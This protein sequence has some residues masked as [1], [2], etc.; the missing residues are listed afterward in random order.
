MDKELKNDV[1]FMFLSIT[2]GLY[3]FGVATLIQENVRHPSV[4]Q[5]LADVKNL[6]MTG[7]TDV[8]GAYSIEYYRAWPA[9]HFI[10]TTIIQITGT[11]IETLMKYMPLF[12]LF[13]F[14]ILVYGA[15]KR[16]E[17]TSN[18]C[19]L[20]TLLALSSYFPMQSDSSP[21]GV[22]ILAYIPCFV[23]LTTS[24]SQESI[25]IRASS[26]LFFT[27]LILLHGFTSL[28]VILGL[29]SLSV[30]R[31]L[32]HEKPPLIIS[33]SVLFLTWYVYQAYRALV[34]G[35]RNWLTAPWDYI[36][37][38]G[39]HLE[40]LY[41]PTYKFPSAII[42]HYSQIFYII[43]YGIL[44]IIA[45][46]YILRN[47]KILK[48]RMQQVIPPL[49]W[50][51]GVFFILFT[52]PSRETYIR[53]FMLLLVPMIFTIIGTFTSHKLLI[54]LLLLCSAFI[55]PARYGL[56]GCFGQVLTTELVGAQFFGYHRGAVEPYYFYDGGE[57]HKVL[58][59][60]NPDA[61]TW[62][63]RWSVSLTEDIPFVLNHASYVLGGK[64]GGQTV[65]NNW[66]EAGGGKEAM[67]VYNNGDFR[68]YK[69]EK[70]KN[71]ETIYL[72][73]NPN[74]K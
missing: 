62:P 28:A 61:I 26:L 54:T 49:V 14:T 27:S 31:R 17:L 44:S 59:F 68:I 41:N 50:I 70:R 38:G 42:T 33:F 58:V 55:L 72:R 18:R 16:M 10:A 64:Q 20:A 7:H 29:F 66:I 5:D 1:F 11:S 56:E 73:N 15:A 19:F 3:I 67:L 43:T 39:T 13:S 53:L 30:Y 25:A 34:L 23:L 60:S 21:Q 6:L 35:I 37:T 9:T 57:A 40:G 45:S 63:K 2:L 32:N 65:I 71:G 69:N 22:A 46:V 24:K 36:V 52:I 74:N 12:W 47:K 8:G 51:I 48:E 4:Y